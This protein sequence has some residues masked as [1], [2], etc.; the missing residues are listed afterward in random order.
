MNAKN[1]QIIEDTVIPR[2]NFSKNYI[3]LFLEISLE[4]LK[5]KTIV[6]DGYHAYSGIVE[7][8]GFNHQRCSF[9]SMQNLMDDLVK[10]H[11]RLNRKI[12][13][14]N[15]QITKL[16]NEIKEIEE[17]YKGQK[18]RTRKDDTQRKKR[19]HSQKGIKKRIKR[20]KSPTEKI[21]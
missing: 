14:L 4:D 20:E 16:E 17:K 19:Q 21:Q 8:L 9:H 12:K 1:K 18:G 13:T 7:E 15:S 10:K 5:V 6:T 2:H 11:N 3:K